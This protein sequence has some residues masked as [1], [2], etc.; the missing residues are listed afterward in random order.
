MK[1]LLASYYCSSKNCSGSRIKFLFRFALIS[2][3]DFLQCTF[4]AGFRNNFQ[5]NRRISKQLL[6]LKWFSVSR[7]KLPVDYFQ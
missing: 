7:N 6:E 3:V 1:F 2:L 4:T 5:D